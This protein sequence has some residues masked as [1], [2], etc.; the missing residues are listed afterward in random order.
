MKCKNIPNGLLK[1]IYTFNTY[2]KKI[3]TPVNYFIIV[4][5]K[6]EYKY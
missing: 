1:D 3:K 4:W 2:H 5:I 6:N